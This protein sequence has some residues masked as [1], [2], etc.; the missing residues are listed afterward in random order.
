[1]PCRTNTCGATRGHACPGAGK[2]RGMRHSKGRS[3]RLATAALTRP[4]ARPMF[5]C[6]IGPRPPRCAS[7]GDVGRLPPRRSTW[8]RRIGAMRA[9]GKIE[10]TSRSRRCAASAATVPQ[11]PAAAGGR[12]ANHGDHPRGGLLIR[13]GRD[14]GSRAEAPVAL[15]RW[16][17]RCSTSWA[18]GDRPQRQWSCSGH[19]SRSITTRGRLAAGSAVER[20]ERRQRR[21]SR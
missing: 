10:R 20:V 14:T 7:F 21:M 13:R 15:S 19:R 16:S 8:L 9:S 2:P 3:P 6:R 18:A 17:R 4:A 5:R 1:M 12:L 11:A